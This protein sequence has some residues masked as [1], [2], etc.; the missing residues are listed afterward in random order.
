[1]ITLTCEERGEQEKPAA[2]SHG[3]PLQTHVCLSVS[4]F[5]WVWGGAVRA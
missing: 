5:L 2:S 1:M 3:G 4:V